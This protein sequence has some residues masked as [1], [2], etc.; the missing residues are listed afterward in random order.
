[1]EGFVQLFALAQIVSTFVGVFTPSL[2]GLV[3]VVPLIN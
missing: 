2:R 3:Y 1:M